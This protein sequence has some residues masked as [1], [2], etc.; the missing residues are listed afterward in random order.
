ML[1]YGGPRGAKL[2]APRVMERTMGLLQEG[3]KGRDDYSVLVRKINPGSV[4]LDR[5]SRNAWSAPNVSILVLLL[6]HLYRIFPYGFLKVSENMES[7]QLRISL[8]LSGC[9]NGPI[10][11]TYGSPD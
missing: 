9:C 10:F 2:L 3:G 4:R 11:S 5:V 7:S 6:H 8:R 1:G